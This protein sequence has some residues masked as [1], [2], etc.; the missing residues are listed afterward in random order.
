M[1]AFLISMNVPAFAP[2]RRRA[3]G[4]RYANGPTVAPS[5]RSHESS[6]EWRIVTP[7]PTSASTSVLFAPIRQWDPMSVAPVSVQK[8]SMTVSRP[9]ETSASIVVEAGSTTVTPSR[10]SA[11]WM[12]AWAIARTSARPAR[13]LTPSVSAASATTCAAIAW[14]AARRTGSTSG[15]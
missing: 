13:S 8:G 6:H 3:P 1:S 2:S 10:M 14:P 11:S 9:T 15:R 12:R 7:S 5:W 4:R